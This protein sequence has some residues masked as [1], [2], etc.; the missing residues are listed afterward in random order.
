MS[1]FVLNFAGIPDY[2][3]Q[4]VW[5]EF[6]DPDDQP[7]DWTGSSFEMRIGTTRGDGAPSVTLTQADGDVVPSIVDG[8]SRITWRFRPE[9]IGPLGHGNFVHDVVRI[10]DGRPIAFAEGVIAINQGV[11]A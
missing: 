11:K 7:Y 6:T 5:V 4:S 2:A 3:D 9:K 8:K 10:M 1:L